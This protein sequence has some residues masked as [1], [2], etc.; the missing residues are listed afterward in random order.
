[1]YDEKLCRRAFH[2]EANQLNYRALGHVPHVLA[3]GLRCLAWR[4]SGGD[5]PEMAGKDV[6]GELTF[7]GWLKR[8][9]RTGNLAG[10]ERGFHCARV[11]VG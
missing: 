4:M 1:M 10:R 2:A 7:L 3:Q 8:P 5:H 6:H 11:K 9:G